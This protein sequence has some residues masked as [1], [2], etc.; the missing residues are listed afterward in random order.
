VPVVAGGTYAQAQAALA[1]E[2]LKAT[3]QEAFSIDIATGTVIG[4]DPTA[5]TRV[6]KDK[7]V[8]VIVSKGPQPHVI[9]AL[10]G[11]S[12]VAARKALEDAK[13][14]VGTDVQ[15]FTDAEKGTV[16]SASVTQRSDGKAIDCSKG[17]TVHE[18]DAGA[19]V[20]SAGRLPSV[21]GKSVDDA[22]AALTD[23]GLKVSGNT[24]QQYSDSID[25]GQ[26]VGIAPR[27]GG[28]AWHVGDTVTLIVSQGQQPV[29]I[30]KNIIGKTIRKAV[31][32]LHRLGFK[33][34]PGIADTPI[35][36]SDKTAW[37]VYTVGST[38]PP[39]GTSAPKGS[40]VTISP[41]FG[42]F[43]G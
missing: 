8:T 12:S 18:G 2:S 20:V 19:L 26:V 32:A 23:R 42:N 40:T 33:V 21:A 7:L 11:Q 10:A 14:T 1:E 16:V 41:T 43:N 5:G 15:V 22:T 17:C 36:F 24:T 31:D 37:D 13:V 6:A 25:K 35:I 34:D 3:P 28:G 4:T 9:P 30:P 39:A 29:E 27:A 38:D